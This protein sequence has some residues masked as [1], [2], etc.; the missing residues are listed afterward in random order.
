VSWYA[1][2]VNE[3]GPA[4]D[5]SDTPGPVIYINLTDKAGSFANTWFYAAN[6][7]QKQLLDVGI[8]AING[9]QDVEVGATSPLPGNNPYTGISRI[10]GLR[11][12]P[13]EAPTDFHEVSLSPPAENSELA[14][15]VVGWKDNSSN[16]DSFV[17]RYS[18]TRSG[19]LNAEGESAV[20]ANTVTAILSLDAGYTYNI[21]VAAVNSAGEAA[22]NTITVTM[23]VS[24]PPMASLSA[25]VGSL[26]AN[27]SNFGL[28]IEGKNFGASE[29]VGII[30]DWKVGDEDSVPF[31]LDP[32]TTD[33]LGYFQVWFAGV[34]PD[35]FCPISEPDGESQPPQHFNV[36]AAGQTSN[37][38]ASTTAG[39]FTCPYRDT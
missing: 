14:V 25:A 32:Q 5:A 23:P 24:P 28:S 27:E 2:T 34:T 19:S 3:V 36:S 11:P 33:S 35:G 26:P 7:I 30:V 10:Y 29:P 12:Q 9:R 31:Q 15:L 13:P 4:S 22:S 1:C 38:T 8:A 37:K 6:G 20:A 17:V 16:E 39:P 21:Y 18:G